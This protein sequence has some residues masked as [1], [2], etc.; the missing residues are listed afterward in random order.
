MSILDTYNGDNTNEVRKKLECVPN[1]RNRFELQN[2]RCYELLITHICGVKK[3]AFIKF[4]V[5]HKYW[6]IQILGKH[7]D[8]FSRVFIDCKVT[9]NERKLIHR[10]INN[11]WTDVH[12]IIKYIFYK[13]TIIFPRFN[14]CYICENDIINYLHQ[15]FVIV[16]PDDNCTYS[17]CICDMCIDKISDDFMN[18]KK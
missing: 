1:F 15:S 16:H 7:T 18:V 3:P 10:Y 2:D 9:D 8:P 13:D 12:Q 4:D 11:G 6:A 5:I 14:Q 17:Q